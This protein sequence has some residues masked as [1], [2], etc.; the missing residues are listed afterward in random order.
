MIIDFNQL[1][2][3]EYPAFKGGEKSLKAK[4]FFDGTNR[5]LYG[6]LIPGATIGLHTHEGNCEMIYILEGK[7]TV[8]M[9]GEYEDVSS[10]VCHYCPE[11][12][13]HSLINNSDAALK[14]FAVVPAQ[15]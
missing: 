3:E 7:G 12:H 10:G 4:M 11:G 2:P 14:F 8:L 13:S 15:K 1:P 6:E 5:I 9:D